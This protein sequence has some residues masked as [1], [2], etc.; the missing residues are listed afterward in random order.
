MA[1]ASTKFTTQLPVEFYNLPTGPRSMAK[2]IAVPFYR[3]KVFGPQPKERRLN[4]FETAILRLLMAGSYRPEKIA[5]RLHLEVDLVNLILTQLMNRGLLNHDCQLTEIG[6]QEM[7][8]G[9]WWRAPLFQDYTTGYI[10][11]N[12]WDSKFQP[13][14]LS[15]TNDAV[16]IEEKKFPV[17]KLGSK[18]RKIITEA[19][20]YLLKDFERAPRTATIQD[21]LEIVRI[22]NWASRFQGTYP[23]DNSAPPRIEKAAV[24][25]ETPE[26]V[27]V[28]TSIYMP[29][30]RS[31]PQDWLV[32]DPF[33][34]G[35]SD[36]IRSMVETYIESDS[37]LLADLGEICRV[38]QERLDAE[39]KTVDDKISRVVT[40]EL[41]RR[42]GIGKIP[43]QLKGLLRDLE[44]SYQRG[45]SGGKWDDMA[46][47]GQLVLEAMLKQ[48]FMEHRNSYK[49]VWKL[50]PRDQSAFPDPHPL[51]SYLSG[52]GHQV[53]IPKLIGKVTQNKVRN[54]VIHGASLRPSFV[55]GLLAAYRAPDHPL[56]KI[57]GEVPKLM[58]HVEQISR[59][60]DDEAHAGPQ[61]SGHLI[62]AEKIRETTYEIITS[63]LSTQQEN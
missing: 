20:Y 12:P 37:I 44:Y 41:D 6:L 51:Q 49:E 36:S 46:I 17:F 9:E 18:N 34:L 40:R 21:I 3:Y 57:L 15:K 29:Q 4:I 13:R 32:K 63:Y 59:Q 19:P 16:M 24:L 61:K 54:C 53:A 60:R 22:H 11:Q 26:K 39:L 52:I 42:F 28:I 55:T 56:R 10:Y 27:W 7:R 33:G 47:R 25:D 31:D 5:Q 50:L 43:L 14:F 23:V 2:W 35:D 58:D 45:R 38:A 1:N 62:S 30:D 48:I 8:E